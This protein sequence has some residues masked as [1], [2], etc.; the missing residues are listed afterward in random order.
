MYGWPARI[1]R[2]RPS[3]RRLSRVFPTSAL[4]MNT[5]HAP[6]ISLYRKARALPGVKKY[7]DRVRPALRPRRPFA[8]IREGT[9]F[10]PRWRLPQDCP[11]HTEENVLA[12]DEAGDRRHDKFKAMFEKASREA[13]K[14]QYLIPYFIAAHP[15]TS[16]RT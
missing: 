4:Y 7:P 8:G 12:H 10:A 5:D 1:R 15:G 6:L 14:E 9:G 13:G 16:T 2:S 11:E 3:C